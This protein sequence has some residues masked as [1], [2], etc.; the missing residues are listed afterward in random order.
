M[1]NTSAARKQVNVR[2]EGEVYDQLA[3]RAKRDRR[4][5]PQTARL[6]LSDALNVPADQPFEQGSDAGNIAALATAGGAF[7]WVAEEPEIY[8]ATPGEPL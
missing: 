6:L 2:V 1:A 5:I 8:A 3:A 7:E 4:S